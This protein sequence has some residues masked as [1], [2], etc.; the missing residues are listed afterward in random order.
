MLKIYK[1]ARAEQDLIT[2]WLYSFENWGEKQ[3]DAYYDKL[4]AA[5]VVIAKNPKLGKS[6][7]DVRDGYRKYRVQRHI[8]FYRIEADGLH[9]IRVLGDEMDYQRHM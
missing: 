5:L 3:A 2:I 7:D 9:V 6:C 1:S 8:I 4:M